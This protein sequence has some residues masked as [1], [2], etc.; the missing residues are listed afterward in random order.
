MENVKKYLN[1]IKRLVTTQ[2]HI[3]KKMLATSNLNI[4]R[5]I[6]EIILNIYYK[7]VPLSPSALRDLKKRKTVLLQLISHNSSLAAKK[8]LLV[9]HSD[10]FVAIKDL[11][12][13][14]KKQTKNE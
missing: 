8:D 5:A 11:F 10:S 6:C 2:P 1:F 9:K 14:K 3:R 13:K 7:H 4:V 12:K